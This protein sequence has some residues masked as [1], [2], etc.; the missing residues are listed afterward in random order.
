MMLY[1]GK[2]MSMEAI[3]E[4]LGVNKSTISRTL[5]RGQKRLHRCLR[6]GA[7]ILLRQAEG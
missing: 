4:Q 1:Y 3:A 6:Y 5:R 2:C 7:A